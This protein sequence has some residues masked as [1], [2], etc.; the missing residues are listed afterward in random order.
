[1]G[2]SS[3]ST[4]PAPCWV[5]CRHERTASHR[6]A[7]PKLDEREVLAAMLEVEPELATS[8]PGLLL[9]AD[10]GFRAQVTGIPAGVGDQIQQQS[11]KPAGMRSAVAV[12]RPA[13][14]ARA[15]DCGTRA[16]AFHRGGV[17]NPHVV[18][19]E[20][21]VGRQQLIARLISGSAARSRRL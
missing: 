14:Q 4:K 20:I 21:G 16:A 12:V 17:G 8:R 6:W 11:P 19:P 10:Q 5:R 9:V 7:H 13:R 2:S 18:Q 3:T 15:L 1:M